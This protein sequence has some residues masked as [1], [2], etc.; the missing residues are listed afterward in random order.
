MSNWD[1]F[2]SEFTEGL[3]FSIGCLLSPDAD[4]VKV[5][6]DESGDVFGSLK[7]FFKGYYFDIC[8][9]VSFTISSLKVA[10]LPDLYDVR[11]SYIDMLSKEKTPFKTVVSTPLQAV[12]AILLE[13]PRTLS[14]FRL[15]T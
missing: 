2:K 15:K 5:D 11:W 7:G 4:H 6:W 13:S 8:H 12:T 9:D 3:G 1:K 10:G 14:K